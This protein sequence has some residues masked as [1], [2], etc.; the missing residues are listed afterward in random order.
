MPAGGIAVVPAD[1][2]ELE[3]FLG[4]TDIEI[5]R[6][7]RSSVVRLD[8]GNSLVRAS[9]AQSSTDGAPGRTWWEF[10][11]PG[12]EGGVVEQLELALPF[13]QRHLAENLLAALT[14]YRAL[15]LPLERAQDGA[16]RITLSRWRSDVRSLPDGGIVVNDA[17]NANPTSMRAA[18]L[19]LV[20]R[21]GDRRRVAILGEMAELGAES[22]RYHGKV[23]EL[24]RELGIEVVIGVGEPA[25]AYLAAAPESHWVGGAGDVDQIVELVRPGDAVLVKAS[26]A[27]GLEGIPHEIEKK[28]GAWSAS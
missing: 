19:D 14:A 10:E 26:R 6:F 7:D 9:S 16:A 4:R 24:I 3:P 5:R 25:R 18:L 21:A 20:E 27:V 15:G 2:P 23:A 12:G 13:D 22:E 11:V 1:T 28:A 8:P 17:Y